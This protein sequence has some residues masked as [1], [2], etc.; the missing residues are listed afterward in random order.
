MQRVVSVFIAL[1]FGLSMYTSAGADSSGIGEEAQMKMTDV[2]NISLCVK[3]AGSGPDM[4]LI[5]GRGF[6]KESIDPLFTYYQDRYHV[7]SYDV[8]GHG[9]TIA[10][11]EFTLDDLSDDLAALIG[12]YGSEKPIVIGFSMGSYIAL[13]TAERYPDLLSKMV[14][15]GTRGGRTHSP[16]PTN[17]EVGRALESFDNITDAQD[18][19][20]PALVLTGEYD[21]IN[22][23]EE[24]Q[25]VADVL[26]DS[27][28]AVVPGAEHMAYND[29]LDFVVSQI[30]AFLA[31]ESE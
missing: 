8:R 15:I 28:Y 24:G 22:P 9:E 23:P 1:L 18:V 27:R 20:I 11:G 21:V 14:L 7:I 12:E 17:D 25:I 3:E 2:N 4:Y 30:D 26:P 5:H 19:A 6:S 16:F 31:E 10:P 13:K 29:N